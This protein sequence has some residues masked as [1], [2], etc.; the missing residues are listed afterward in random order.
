[1]RKQYDTVQEVVRAIRD[2]PRASHKTIQESVTNRL[3]QMSVGRV[4]L[5]NFE[6]GA[7][8]LCWVNG[9][10]LLTDNKYS[11]IQ[12]KRL[13]AC[14][15]SLLRRLTKHL[16][17]I[18]GTDSAAKSKPRQIVYYGKPFSYY[19]HVIEKPRGK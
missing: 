6:T 9:F 15:N 4:R 10:R 17:G 16:S 12:M 1:M 18:E 11:R 3:V 8:E 2:R 7:N 19:Y 5:H 14:R 13:D